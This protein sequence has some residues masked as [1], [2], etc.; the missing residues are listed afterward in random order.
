M[1]AAFL[2]FIALLSTFSNCNDDEILSHDE[3]LRLLKDLMGE[4]QANHVL[5]YAES[6]IASEARRLEESATKDQSTA[7]DGLTYIYFGNQ[8]RELTSMVCN[9]DYMQLFNLFGRKIPTAYVTEMQDHEY[10]F[11]DFSCCSN[12]H[13]QQLMKNFAMNINRLRKR[14]R[15]LIELLNFFRG[16][17]LRR[18][19][20]AHKQNPKCRYILFDNRPN[21]INLLDDEVIKDYQKLVLTF[22]SQIKNFIDKKEDFFGNMLC[23]ICSPK[24]QGFIEYSDVNDSLV[25][26]VSS[27]VCNYVYQDSSFEIKM[28][29]IFK[30][31]VMKIADFMECASGL[32]MDGYSTARFFV[33]P[34]QVINLDKMCYNN[35]TN[36]APS[37]LKFCKYNIDFFKYDQYSQ[38]TRHIRQTL[39]IYYKVLTQNESTI[40]DHYNTVYGYDLHMGLENQPLV[41]YSEKSPMAMKYNIK[42]YTIKF[43]DRGGLNPFMTPISL[44]FWK[45]IEYIIEH[46]GK[47]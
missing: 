36:E 35:F 15:P 13:F 12:E 45:E 9:R 20:K 14:F 19:L 4:E 26:N 42:N 33:Y 5:T 34:K 7:D 23:S 22:I 29:Y 6:K 11:T 21:S 47:S 24:S 38:F 10:C 44:A 32:E 30:N 40:E 8:S 31:V 28:K 43:T 27:E 37:C 3:E 25:F 39:R 17:K 18:F 46:S 16:T 2:I 41:I 1:K